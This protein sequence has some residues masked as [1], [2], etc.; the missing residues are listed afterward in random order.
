MREKILS[1]V[2]SKIVE[3]ILGS[4]TQEQTKHELDR[5]IDRLEELIASTETQL[6][7]AL[8]P[9][10]RFMREVIDVPDYPDN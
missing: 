6:D 2:I 7:D 4:L 10:L 8:M 9:A 5:L 3:M 1:L